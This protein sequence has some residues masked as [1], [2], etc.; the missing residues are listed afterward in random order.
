MRQRALLMLALAC[1]TGGTAVYLARNWI[2]RQAQ[3]QIATLPAVPPAAMTTVVVAKIP[4]KFGDELSRESLREIAWPADATPDGSF[5]TMDELLS[6]ERRVALR[7]MGPNEVVLKARVSGFGGKATLSAVIGEGMRAATIRVNDVLGVAGF[8]LPGDMVDVVF[9]RPEDPTPGVQSPPMTDILLQSVKV[10][11]VDQTTGDKDKPIPAKAVTLEVTANDAQRLALAGQM[12]SL[13]LALRQTGGV[14]P[15]AAD[16]I[17]VG[18]LVNHGPEPMPLPIAADP[19]TV[20]PILPA[21]ANVRIVRA[22]EESMQE[23]PSD[24]PNA[25]KAGSQRTERGRENRVAAR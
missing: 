1:V 8:V 17:R 5:K 16:T 12:G 23:V 6:G 4:L 11:A 21:Q 7:D 22:L 18:N 25:P 24:R 3:P 2:A 13:G 14:Q 9:T 19:P 15:V 10:L 20:Q